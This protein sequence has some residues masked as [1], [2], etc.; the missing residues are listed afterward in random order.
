[1]A[2]DTTTVLRFNSK[3]GLNPL[4]LTFLRWMMAS[5]AV[6]TT[7]VARVLDRPIHRADGFVRSLLRLL[8]NRGVR[9]FLEKPLPGGERVYL[10]R[11]RR[12]R[13]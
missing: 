10:Y 13:R 12:E 4:Q 5:G 1:M 11:P 6:R 3:A 7:D 9:L 8:Q 2:H